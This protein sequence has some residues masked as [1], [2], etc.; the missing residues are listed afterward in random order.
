MPNIQ[1]NTTS[2]VANHLLTVDESQSYLK[3]S[4]TFLW[5]IRKQGLI[6][7]VKAGPKKVLL[8]KSSIDHY[9]KLNELGHG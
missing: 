6:K 4:R 1:I 8:T 2:D 3:C 5:Q 9:L 7:T